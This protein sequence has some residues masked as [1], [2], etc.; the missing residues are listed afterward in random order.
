M[1]HRYD[2]SESS[3]ILEVFTR[4][5]GR[6]ALVA[7]VAVE[8]HAALRDQDVVRAV[9]ALVS[10]AG[11]QDTA[12]GTAIVVVVT[13]A[14]V[15]SQLS[16]ASTVADVANLPRLWSKPEAFRPEPVTPTPQVTL[17]TSR[18]VLLRLEPAALA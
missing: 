4:R 7:P 1:L 9:R 18:P 16:A 10:A 6:I 17:R 8:L 5:Q 2:W 13:A 15:P 11:E 14:S 12:V 3:L